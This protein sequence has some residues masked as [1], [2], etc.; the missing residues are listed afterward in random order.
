MTLLNYCK[1]DN[2]YLS[3]ATDKSKLKINKFTQG[4]QIKVFSDK[5]IILKRARLCYFIGLEFCKRNYKK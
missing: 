5:E 4:G 2:D 3:F 1:I